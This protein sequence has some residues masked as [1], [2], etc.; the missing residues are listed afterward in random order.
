MCSRAKRGSRQMMLILPSPSCRRARQERTDVLLSSARAPIVDD[1]LH[2]RFRSDMQARQQ[3]PLARHGV[4]EQPPLLV[5]GQV[6]QGGLEIGEQKQ[7]RSLRIEQALQEFHRRRREAA[8]PHPF[9]DLARLEPHRIDLPRVLVEFYQLL[10]D[11]RAS[12]RRERE[13]E[14]VA[15]LDPRALGVRRPLGLFDQRLLRG[16]DAG[17]F[18]EFDGLL[19]GGPTEKPADGRLIGRRHKD[20]FVRQS[21]ADRAI[22]HLAPR[23]RLARNGLH[24]SRVC[25]GGLG[26]Q[27]GFASRRLGR[28]SLLFAHC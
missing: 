11:L 20:E 9:V 21:D 26:G 3:R 1:R 17:R 2:I 22:L 25:S 27:F 10:V 12:R 4:H 28:G 14:L 6:A 19:F 18:E 24:R 8:V 15:R 5:V 7:R 16:R 23:P 13:D